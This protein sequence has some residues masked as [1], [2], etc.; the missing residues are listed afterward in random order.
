[1]ESLMNNMG[2]LATSIIIKA[3]LILVGSTLLIGL[4][5]IFA[6]KAVD[7]LLW[8]VKKKK[9]LNSP[10]WKADNMTGEEFEMFLKA[11]L[12][13]SGYQA[14]LTKKSHDYG[15]DLIMTNADGITLIL[16][17]KRSK[18]DIGIAAIQEA[19][20]A[21]SFYRAQKGV[22]ATNRFF[23]KSARELASKSG[24][25]LWN[26]NDIERIMKKSSPATPPVADKAKEQLDIKEEERCPLCHGSLKE[27]SGKYG[28]F[29]G[30]SNYP[31]CKYTKKIP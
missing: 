7:W 19:L 27:R 20:G 26:R 17:A 6:K 28:K 14:K 8:Q 22:V 11:H 4:L 21:V 10:L 9:Y 30:C 31:S 13:K 23:T 5:K 15:A 24:I 1:M 29:Y 12:E 16:Q 3:G 2:S 25:E 18:K